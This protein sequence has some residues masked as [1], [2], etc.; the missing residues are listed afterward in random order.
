MNLS[1]AFRAAAFSL[2]KVR[3]GIKPGDLVLDIGSG[4]NP[5]P[6]ADVVCDKFIENSTHRHS[7]LAIYTPV[8]AGDIEHLPFKAKV[9]DFV[10][11]SHVLE[12]V[13][14]PA[15]ACAE[16]SRVGRRGYIET[17]SELFERLMGGLPSHKWLVSAPEGRLVF[18]SK[19][20]PHTDE[21]LAGLIWTLKTQHNA[22]LEDF[23]V[24]NSRQLHLML[25]WTDQ[26]SA[27]VRRH[28]GGWHG[29]QEIPDAPNSDMESTPSKVLDLWRFLLRGLERGRRRNKFELDAIL[30]CPAC[31]GALRD[32]GATLRCDACR[33][34]YPIQNGI[35]RL[36]LNEAEAP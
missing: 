9:F 12:H 5:L 7:R 34:R 27:D 20:G 33:I 19:A 21:R 11:C 36:L 1:N 10:N 18:E 4:N 16:L 2:R 6:R 24:R 17:P 28:D 25:F 29:M 32:D 8:V 26:I 31:R 14:N 13:D 3:M 30:A 22:G 23:M 15:R 35:P